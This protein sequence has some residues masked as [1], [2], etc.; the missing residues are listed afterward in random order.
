MSRRVGILEQAA[1]QIRTVTYQPDNVTGIGTTEKNVMTV[2]VLAGQDAI[3]ECYIKASGNLT[4]TSGSGNLDVRCKVDGTAVFSV[5]TDGTLL[6][7][8]TTGINARRTQQGTSTGALGIPGGFIVVEQ[9]A[10]SPT[11]SPGLRTVEFT[12]ATSATGA[13]ASLSSITIILRCS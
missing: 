7:F 10:G 2:D 6:S 3:I 1:G 9:E 8:T 13:T 5:G 4:R 11:W 12:T